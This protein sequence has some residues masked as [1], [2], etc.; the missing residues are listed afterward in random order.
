MSE[1]SASRG[2]R[3]GRSTGEHRP[4]SVQVRSGEAIAKHLPTFALGQMSIRRY[5]LI[6][7]PGFRATI[8]PELQ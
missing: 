8:I 4:F 6:A 2:L 3:I 1:K 5:R 7:H